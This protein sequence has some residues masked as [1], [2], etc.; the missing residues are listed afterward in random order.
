MAKVMAICG[1]V[2]AGKSYYSNKLKET[3]N[4]VVL[5]CDE[6]TKVIFDNN[7]NEK[8][9]ET[10]V[11]IRRYLL[12]KAEDIIKTGTNVIL[13]WGF[14]SKKDRDDLNSYLKERQIKVE[15]HYIDVDDQTW[16]RHIEERNKK[17]LEG[18][19]G[20]DYKV[21]NTLRKKLLTRWQTPSKDEIDVWH[22]VNK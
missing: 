20:S 8:L 14:W 7:L 5:S 21:G 17:V 11:K 22:V 13:E 3:E 1:K 2:C 18:K 4:A 10:L 19:G 12:I 16:E 6:F 15:W 9:D